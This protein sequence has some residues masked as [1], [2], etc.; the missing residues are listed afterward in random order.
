MKGGK[1]AWTDTSLYTLAFEGT[2]PSNCRSIPYRIDLQWL[3]ISCAKSLRQYGFCLLDTMYQTSMIFK[4]RLAGRVLLYLRAAAK[5]IGMDPSSYFSF[6]KYNA[7]APNLFQIARVGRPKSPPTFAK[8]KNHMD[9]GLILTQILR[10]VFSLFFQIF[11]KLA[12]DI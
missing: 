9:T 1:V 2:Q 5:R 4:D 3:K 10:I 12:Y 7:K 11:A 8:N 6:E